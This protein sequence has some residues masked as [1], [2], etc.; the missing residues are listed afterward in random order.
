MRKLFIYILAFF[1]TG[2][3]IIP[4]DE[5]LILIDTG[6]SGRRHVLVEYTGFRCV[7]CPAAAE[8]ARELEERYEG[9][10][11]IVSLHPASNPFT[12]G[13][14]DYTC[15]EADSIYRWMGGNASTP[16]PTGNIDLKPY[17]GNWFIDPQEW[18]TALYE[19]MKD[20]LVPSP[21]EKTE[22]AYWLIE[23]SVKGAQAMPDNSVNMEYYHR[24]VLRAIADKE[25][26][27][28]PE[29]CD[30]RHLSVLVLTL[31]PNDKHIIQAYEKKLYSDT[32]VSFVSH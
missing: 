7:N 4:A 14:Y 15:P 12:Q 11:Y 6:E 10:L 31:D 21:E 3:E 28:I 1:F 30:A 29:G 9:Q 27:D 32:P 2:C 23:D 26:I 19:T 17:N 5:Q 13:K 8:K 20:K 24:H 22:T 18:A 16:F 25:P